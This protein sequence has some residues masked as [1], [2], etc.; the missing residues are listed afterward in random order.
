[1]DNRVLRSPREASKIFAL[2]TPL[3]PRAKNLFYVRFNT[4]KAA[5][6]GW[7]K[8][9]SFLVKTVE[10]PSIT[11][12]V[13]ELNQYNK[14]R[15]VNVG[16]KTAPMRISFYDTVDGTAMQMWAEYAKEFFGDFRHGDSR[17]DYRYDV[18]TSAF[19]DTGGSGFGFAP[20][21]SNDD[22]AHFFFDSISV[23]QVMGKQYTQ[24]DLIN[25]KINSFDPEDL[26]YEDS[27]IA[28]IT[29]SVAYEAI[30]YVNDGAPMSFSNDAGLVDAFDGKFN[31]D[32]ID[33]PATEMSLAT[34]PK[35]SE[36][37]MTET[38]RELDVAARTDSY[39]QFSEEKPDL[40]IT[41]TR[42][43]SSGLAVYGF[44]NF[45]L[46]PGGI[47]AN[48]QT[49][50]ALADVAF[51][52]PASNA[53]AAVLNISTERSKFSSL[54]ATPYTAKGGIHTASWDAA[55]DVVAA[56]GKARSDTE[57]G[58]AVTKAVAGA[59]IST[60]KSARDQLDDKTFRT[61][62]VEPGITLRSE[63]YGLMNAQRSPTS[64]VGFNPRRRGV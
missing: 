6:A 49:A 48:R 64:Q 52:V 45:G 2:G 8:D 31:G 3:A 62:M 16:Y 15:Q 46:P 34:T 28:T 22:N 33:Y 19:N 51:T 11:P 44:Y 55:K 59:S 29:I 43:A 40:R 50:D 4:A 7:R 36:T 39:F 61:A 63:V 41:A 24:F 1:M 32:V 38:Q 18:T 47:L 57:I 54:L 23:F 42:E 21:L 30:I 10:R 5:S 25:P 20:R 35:R 12:T 27:N 56:K 13:E 37:F 17:L 9:L 14:R 26:S 60:S 53:L 58:L